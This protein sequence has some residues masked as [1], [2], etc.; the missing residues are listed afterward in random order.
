LDEVDESAT[1]SAN[2]WS[3]PREGAGAFPA[4]VAA[5]AERPVRSSA[6]MFSTAEREA[7]RSRVLELARS[8]PRVVAGA[9]VG[10]LA[11]DGGD[12]FS[13][14]D[15]TFGV[16]DA[17]P[18]EVLDDL[19]PRLEAELGAARLF[20]LASGATLYRVFLLPG[21]LQVDLSC[22][23]AAR[24]G[25]GSPRWQLLFGGEIE[26]PHAGP[27]AAD[28]LFGLGAHHALR[29]RVCIERGK[30]WQAEHW[31]GELRDQ[32]LALACRRHGLPARYG[33]GFDD[34]PAE[35]LSRL[36]EARPRSLARGELLRALA[37]G[38]EGLL[39][40]A[41]EARG[42]ADRVEADLRALTAPDWA[43][44]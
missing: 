12:R 43:G 7:A 23:P 19:T 24:F 9:L 4:R 2:L 14:L 42:L 29:V 30:P 6:A 27:P 16:E 8:D 28:E 36:A 21:A 31:L 35:V 10:S 18:L 20:D 37:H 5:F 3:G 32:A 26:R 17:E 39:R 11:N 34:L 22:T 25:A 15:L 33:R 38:V 1:G 13:D 40:E 44:I 41:D